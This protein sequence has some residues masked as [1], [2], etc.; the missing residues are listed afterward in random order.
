[1]L[2]FKREP[3]ESSSTVCCSVA[4]KWLCPGMRRTKR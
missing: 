3:K 4:P 2:K 1:M